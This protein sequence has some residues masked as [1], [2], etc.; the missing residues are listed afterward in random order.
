MTKCT[1]AGMF[2]IRY[3]LFTVS[4][5]IIVSDDTLVT[6][7]C[8]YSIKFR[9]ISSRGPKD[10]GMENVTMKQICVALVKDGV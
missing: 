6:F 9:S 8:C 3:A 7:V 10:G 1:N 2:M 5:E 4:M